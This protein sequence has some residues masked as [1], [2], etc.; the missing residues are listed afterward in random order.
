M[1]NSVPPG[2]RLDQIR[3]PQDAAAWRAAVAAAYVR[4]FAE[5]PY[6]EEHTPEEAGRVWDRLTRVP[7]HVTLVVSTEA[8]ELAAFASAIPLSARPDVAREL[9]GLVPLR[10]TWYLAELAVQPEHRSQ[11]LARLLI[12]ER[13][14][15]MERLATHAIMRVSESD[16]RS[17]Q[18]YLD[19]GFEDMGVY[20]EVPGP[21]VDGGVRADRRLFLH[22]VLSQVDLG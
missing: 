19:L 1:P 2:Y 10:H 14:R 17:K 8:G 21:R 13:L 22:R 12:R 6:F 4:I 16:N 5:A 7:G 20:M 11:G 15:H 3:S 18:M 9:T